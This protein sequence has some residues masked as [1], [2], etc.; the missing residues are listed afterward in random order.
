MVQVLRWLVACSLVMSA[1]VLLGMPAT[2]MILAAHGPP[3]ITLTPLPDLVSSRTPPR[4][5]VAGSELGARSY[6]GACYREQYGQ[7]IHV[8]LQGR[9]EDFGYAVD[10]Y[11][12]GDLADGKDPVR[13]RR[14]GRDSIE[15]TQQH[16]SQGRSHERENG[17]R[18]GTRS[19]SPD[20]PHPQRHE[21]VQVQER[22]P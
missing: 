14:M 7:I 12:V 17:G 9:A 18:H 11:G 2:G 1:S 5:V 3:P 10:G 16:R 22:E 8:H 4:A 20:Q 21:V 13:E 19:A 6:A 15:C